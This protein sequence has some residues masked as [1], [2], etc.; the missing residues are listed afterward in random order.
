MKGKQIKQPKKCLSL[1]IYLSYF[2]YR[3]L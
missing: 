2:G 1:Y 3:I